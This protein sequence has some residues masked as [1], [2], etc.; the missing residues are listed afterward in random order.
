MKIELEPENIRV[1]KFIIKNLGV[2]AA[3]TLLIGLS[4]TC[5]GICQ[6]HPGVTVGLVFIGINILFFMFYL[7]VLGLIRVRDDLFS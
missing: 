4:T 7:L 1:L 5:F 3:P 6:P 2:S